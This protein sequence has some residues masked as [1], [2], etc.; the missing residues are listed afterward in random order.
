VKLKVADNIR[1]YTLDLRTRMPFRYGIATLTSLPHLFLELLLEIDGKVHRGLAAENLAPKWFTKNPDTTLQQDIAQMLT[2]I[3]AACRFAESA[4]PAA[5]VFELW[6]TIYDEQSRW[7][8]AQNLPPLLTQFGVTLVERASIDA[9]CRATG[10]TFADAVRRNAFGLP[11][12]PTDLP[13]QPLRTVI[14]RHTVGISDPLTDA[15][16]SPA[17]KLDDGLPQSL[18]A[19]VRAYGLTHFKIKIH[20][21]ARADAERLRDIAAVLRDHQNVAFTLDGNESYHDLESFRAF[22]AAVKDEPFVRAKM[23]FVEQPLHRDIALTA[24]LEKWFDRPPII[25]DESDAEFDSFTIALDRG[26]AGTSFKG[27]KG[28]FKGIINACLA[29]RRQQA[30]HPTIISAEDLTTLGPVSLFQDLAVVATLGIPH[31]ERN[32][33]HYFRGLAMFPPDVQQQVL[34]H[35]GDLYH[36]SRAGFPT[37]DI[38]DGRIAIDSIVNAPFGYATKLDLTQVTGNK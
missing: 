25:I 4:A 15:E 21:D 30:G 24:G 13:A 12:T 33:H 28:V 10:Q 14:A 2:V 19:C 32:G 11:E 36:Q 37:L 17:E 16:I 9:F 27:C 38:R 22:W 34:Q 3:R 6:R 29:R 8:A 35:H 1:L 7:G 23:L 18:Q 20:G 26:Y 5:S 31:V